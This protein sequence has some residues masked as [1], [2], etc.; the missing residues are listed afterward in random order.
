[1]LGVLR[2]Q[3]EGLGFSRVQVIMQITLVL[4]FGFSSRF[5]GF[6]AAGSGCRVEGCGFQA[7]GNQRAEASPIFE[8][9]VRLP[10]SASTVLL[11]SSPN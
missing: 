10:K 1:M 8:S 11:R 9:R 4:G 7:F 5:C 2:V 3:V 6:V